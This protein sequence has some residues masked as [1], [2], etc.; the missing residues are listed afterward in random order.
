M[1]QRQ[2]AEA[3]YDNLILLPVVVANQA[4]E[5]TLADLVLMIY[6]V[7]EYFLG[8]TGPDF[9]TKYALRTPGSS[10]PAP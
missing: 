7:S 5:N 8:N 6:A 10:S 2:G 3:E 4:S 9:L 1:V